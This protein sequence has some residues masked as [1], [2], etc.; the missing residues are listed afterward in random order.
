MVLMSGSYFLS[1]YLV[2][3]INLELKKLNIKSNQSKI[4]YLRIH[5]VWNSVSPL[6]YCQ[7]KPYQDFS[8]I[9]WA[10]VYFCRDRIFPISLYIYIHLHVDCFVTVMDYIL[11]ASLGHGLCNINLAPNENNSRLFCYRLT[12][13]KM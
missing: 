9:S 12:G 1:V 13:H 4:P 3:F 2:C 5:V 10:Y 6:N 7:W 11:V 8:F